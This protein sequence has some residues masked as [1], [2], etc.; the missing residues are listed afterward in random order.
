MSGAVGGQRSGPE[1]A[2]LQRELESLRAENER[3]SRLLDLRGQDTA[4]AA[5]Q[6]AVPHATGLVTMRGS[7]VSQ[8]L[9]L[10][11]DRFRTRRDV[12]AIFWE[13][14]RRGTHGWTPA[15]AGGWRNGIDRSRARYLPLTPEV[16]VEHLAPAP[17]FI[18]LYP[19]FADNSCRF[20]VADFDGATAML[21]ALAYAKGGSCRRCADGR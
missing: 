11:A 17:L 3:L 1:L 2:Q 8:K 10:Y 6:L 16:L 12:Y 13:N 14:P 20:L 7:S 21:D 15:V 19:L 4:P 9:A 5:E 18:G